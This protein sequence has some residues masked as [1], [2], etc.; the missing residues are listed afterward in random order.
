MECHDFVLYVF[1]PKD[2]ILWIAV[3][4]ISLR[5]IPAI[6]H[7]SQSYDCGSERLSGNFLTLLDI[8]Y[9]RLPS[10]N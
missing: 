10:E 7:H 1:L 3:S 2:A 9:A 8:E 4:V 5:S 6:A